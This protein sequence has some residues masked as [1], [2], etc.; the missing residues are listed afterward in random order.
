MIPVPHDARL[1]GLPQLLD[2]AAVRERLN[3]AG[4]QVE[5]GQVYYL[6]YKPGTSC[7]A[8]YQFTRTDPTTGEEVPAV[9]YGKCATRDSFEVAYE[10]V[11]AHRWLTTSPGAP[12]IPHEEGKT[13]FFTFPNDVKL[14]ALRS[15]ATPR[16]LRRFMRPYLPDHPATEWRLPQARLTTEVVRYKPERRAVMRSIARAVHEETGRREKVRVYWRVYRDGQVAEMFRRLR[17]LKAASA[18]ERL[19]VP[20]PLGF[21]PKRQVLLTEAVEGQPLGE[22]LRTERRASAAESP[23]PVLAYLHGPRAHTQAESPVSA[24]QR[25]AAALAYLHGLADSRLPSVRPEAHLAHALETAN[26]LAALSPELGREAGQI[27]ARLQQTMPDMDGAAS[28]LHG[29]FYHDQVLVTDERIGFVDF[30]RSHM[31]SRLEDVGNFLAHLTMSKLEGRLREPAELADAFVGSYGRARG[32]RV[33][34]RDLAWWT[35]LSLLSLSTDPFRRFE[36]DWPAKIG[37]ILAAAGESCAS[38]E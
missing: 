32:E 14:V 28:L 30:D 24:V 23:W 35:A 5:G 29:D 13:L 27:R 17:F 9:F 4:A 3:A 2:T 21:D 34:P 11:R 1:S 20:A 36:P 37:A 25:T 19:A 26:M 12:V 7:I 18:S 8:A 15:L 33:S 16:R 31:G 10:K 38:A 22:S 6:R